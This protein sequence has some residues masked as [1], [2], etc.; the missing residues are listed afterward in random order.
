MFRHRSY[1]RARPGRTPSLSCALLVLGCL[2]AAAASPAMAVSPEEALSLINQQRAAYGIPP[3]ALEQ[4]LAKPECGLE[5]HEIASPYPEQWSATSN[6]WDG[7]PWHLEELFDPERVAAS[8][9]VYPSF[10]DEQVLGG[11]GEPWACMWFRKE[12]KEGPIAFYWAAEA[13]GP[14]A[15][16]PSVSAN[17][18]PRTPAEQA[19]LP[20]PTGPNLIVYAPLPDPTYLIEPRSAS[21][22]T[23]TGEAVAS[24]LIPG[25]ADDAIVLI[26]KPV[27]PHAS[28]Q[29][30]VG[31]EVERLFTTPYELTQT[32]DFTT[33]AEP[34]PKPVEK[35]HS[36]EYSP[37][38]VQLRLR[39]HGSTVRL[40]ASK[41]LRGHRVAISIS[42]EWVP[43]AIVFSDKRCTWVQKGH[44][45]QFHRR[46]KK[47]LHLHFRPPDD[48]EKVF[49]S[50]VTR[51]FVRHRL[52]YIEGRAYVTLKGPKPKHR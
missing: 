47:G 49:I 10:Q 2:L 35:D 25:V 28:F 11:Q 45:R 1:P 26:D 51:P 15:V 7:A 21:V 24:N 17:E 43:C 5:N 19:G 30:T 39:A 8:Y 40:S 46:I 52:P 34:P 33:G 41:N 27:Q 38:V 3:L 50:A 48:W 29:V 37:H 22:Q 44:T 36:A 6:P 4:S 18:Y 31:W 13:T 42:R 20:N 16:P 32:F 9:T 14:N 23:A 12:R